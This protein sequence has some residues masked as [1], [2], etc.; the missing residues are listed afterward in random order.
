MFDIQSQTE[1]IVRI[2][3]QRKKIVQKLY[4]YVIVLYVGIPSIGILVDKETLSTIN[5]NQG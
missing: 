5:S 1:K 2:Q 3:S 4:D